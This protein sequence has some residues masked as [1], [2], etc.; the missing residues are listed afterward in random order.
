MKRRREGIGAT[1]GRIVGHQGVF[2]K[3]E[4]SFMFKSQ[5]N[6]LE[7]A[8]SFEDLFSQSQRAVRRRGLLDLGQLWGGDFAQIRE[9]A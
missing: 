1:G 2:L 7:S 8:W 9:E 5:D 4:H 3:L 6:F